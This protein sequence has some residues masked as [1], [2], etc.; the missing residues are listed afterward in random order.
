MNYLDLM[1]HYGLPRSGIIHVGANDAGEA[2]RYAAYS[3]GMPV[4][5]FEP[6]P[7]K[8]A[9][10]QAN[11]A[12]FSNVRVFQECCAAEDGREVTFNI[13]N[14]R[15]MASSMYKL[16]RVAEVHPGIEYV[17]SFTIRTVRADTILR[18]HYRLDD[19]TLAVIDTQGAD[20]EVLKGL[21]PFLDH[22]EAVYV[23]VSDR[24]LYEGGARF[25]DIYAFLKASGF[26]LADLKTGWA[27]TGNAFFK[28]ARPLHLRDMEHAISVG[29]PATQSSDF[30]RGKWPASFG[31][32]GILRHGE[33]KFFCTNVEPEAWWKVDLG[34][35]TAIKA[36]YLYDFVNQIQRADS[37]VVEVSGDD[38]DWT[39]IHERVAPKRGPNWKPPRFQT[40][41]A[42][43]WRGRARYVR[44]RLRETNHLQFKQ[45]AVIAD[46]LHGAKLTTKDAMAVS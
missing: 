23:E 9:E 43:Y 1:D 41:D 5:F 32:D 16:G 33:R 4:A 21:G 26:I 13:S 46:D 19:F 12:P 34:E 2:P 31:N 8:F 24:P 27:D 44:L 39:T 40:V 35:E 42:I 3:R 7:A 15:G 6:T 10:A 38:R 28:R 37:V 22:L 17:G 36:V 25:D 30:A 45:V 18:Q 14:S 29:K 20:L 11:C